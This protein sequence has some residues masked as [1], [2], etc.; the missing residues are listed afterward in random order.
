MDK[1]REHI[2]ELSSEDDVTEDEVTDESDEDEKKENDDKDKIWNMI[3]HSVKL[4]D[5]IMDLVNDVKSGMAQSKILD[6]YRDR[7]NK[8]FHE[9]VKMMEEMHGEYISMNISGKIG[10]TE[11]HFAE[12]GYADAGKMAYEVHKPYIEELLERLLKVVI[13]SNCKKNAET[14]PFLYYNKIRQF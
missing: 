9:S 11:D 2:E 14:T 12:Q 8:T 3:L 13:A 5:D 7:F 6:K 4:Y 10:E 1:Q